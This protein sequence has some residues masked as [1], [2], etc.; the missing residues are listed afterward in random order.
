MKDIPIS[1]AKHGPP[2][3]RKYQYEPTYILRGLSRLYL[4][5]TAA[6]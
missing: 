5:F 4:E 3:A 1:Q 2:G 6:A